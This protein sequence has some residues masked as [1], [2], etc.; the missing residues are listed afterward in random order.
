MSPVVVDE[1]LDMTDTSESSSSHSSD[2]E[3]DI[4]ECNSEMSPDECSDVELLDMT[5]MSESSSSH[6]SD[7]EEDIEELLIEQAKTRRCQVACLSSVEDLLRLQRHEIQI[8]RASEREA[9]YELTED[10]PVGADAEHGYWSIRV[11]TDI[12]E[13]Y[14]SM[15]IVNVSQ[16]S[17]QIFNDI[18]EMGPRVTDRMGRALFEQRSSMFK[19]RKVFMPWFELFQKIWENSRIWYKH[20]F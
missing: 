7:S 1:C 6:S 15:K 20:R 19:K 5:R 2:S 3:G 16:I 17:N 13:E 8:G 14:H 10:V 18:T 4:E 9:E 12:P 11:R